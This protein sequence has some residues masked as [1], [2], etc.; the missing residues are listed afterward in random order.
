MDRAF[1]LLGQEIARQKSGRAKFHGTLQLIKLCAEAGKEAIAQP[2]LDDLTS[3]IEAHKLD[4]WEAP[5]LVA[6]ALATVM[7]MSKKVQGNAA[8]RQKLYDRICR[9]DPVI[10]LKAG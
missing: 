7:K 1:D 10:A 6:D 4:D 3:S 9:L 5:E 2:Y 8:E